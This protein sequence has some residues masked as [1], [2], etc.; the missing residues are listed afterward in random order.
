MQLNFA[1]L[2]IYLNEKK[3]IKTKNYQPNQ[4]KN[5]G[6]EKSSA[7]HHPFL[8]CKGDWRIPILKTIRQ[9]HEQALQRT[10]TKL[11]LQLVNEVRMYNCLD[12]SSQVAE[13]TQLQSVKAQQS[14]HGCEKQRHNKRD[15]ALLKELVAFFF[16]KGFCVHRI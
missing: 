3:K 10:T 2:L 13:T 5:T 8:T 12:L 7:T 6:K 9:A 11:A 15:I 14:G 1:K 16:I 4:P